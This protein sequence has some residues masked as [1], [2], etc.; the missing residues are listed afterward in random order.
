LDDND[1]LRD[2]INSEL[3]YGLMLVE[4]REILAGD[5]TGQHVKGL[6][7]QATAY[8]TALN[9]SGDTKLDVLRHAKLQ[10]RLIGLG[11]AEP[12][13]FVLSPTDMQ[14]IELIKDEYGGANKGRYIIGDPSQ[15]TGIKYLWNLPVVES[16][17]IATGTFLVGPFA[18]GATLVDRMQAMVEISYEHASNFTN[19][20][21]TLLAEE[22]VGLAVRRPD[23]FITGSLPA[24][25]VP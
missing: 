14:K 23:T 18:A 8:N 17:S 12:D 1:W 10:S 4:E 6:I 7:T 16:D 22:R 5:G 13:A 9:V 11:T 19:N 24:T 21:A 20:V 3:L 15:G 25:T 2:A